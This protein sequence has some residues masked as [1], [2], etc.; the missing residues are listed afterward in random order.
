MKYSA[1]LLVARKKKELEF[2]LIHLGGPFW[3]DNDD[4]AWSFPKGLIEAGEEPLDTAKREWK[5]ETGLDLPKGIY[6]QLPYVL[7]SKKKV[8]AFLVLDDVEI[9]DFTSNRFSMEWPKGSKQMQEFPEADKI[10]WCT[11]DVAMRRIHKYLCPL[12][13]NALESL[14]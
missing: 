7:S 2:L 4:G 5:E 13:Q 6:T 12:L 11:S 14:S 8:I 1:G 9:S 3:K 10:E